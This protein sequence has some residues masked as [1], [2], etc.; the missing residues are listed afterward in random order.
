[1]YSVAII[2]W[3]AA[4]MMCMAKLLADADLRGRTDFL[5]ITLFDT[6]QV[7]GT[8]VRISGW[9]RCNVTTSITDKRQL[10]W[11]YIRGAEFLKKSLGMCGPARIY[12]RFED[13]GVPLKIEDDGRVFPVSN[14]WDDV[15]AVFERLAQHHCIDVK[16]QR[17]VTRVAPLEASSGF[18]LDYAIRWWSTDTMQVDA[19]VLATGGS[20]YRHTGSAGDGY[21][22]AQSCG[23]TITPLGPSLNSFLVGEVGSWLQSISGIAFPHGWFTLSDGRIVRWPL[24]ATHFGCSGPGTF[25]LSAHLAFEPITKEYPYRVFLSP[26]LQYDFGFWQDFFVQQAC[27]NPRKHLKTVL[28]WLMPERALLVWLAQLEIA[29]HTIMAELRKYERNILIAACVRWLPIDFIGRR[30]GDEFVTA[31]WVST[32]EVDSA[33][34]ASRIMP[35]LY[36]V[37]EVLDVDGVTGWF[38]LTSSWAT[39]RVA[40]KTLA[41]NV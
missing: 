32:D 35:W 2:G 31:G 5:R 10:L 12:R 27:E 20:A 29:P 15:V 24:L 40:G 34:C 30:P 33:T 18:C 16:L 6:N 19:V 39:G 4:G 36:L 41:L 22:F 13:Q 8:K 14:D 3:W 17:R 26:N 11:S 9:G 1:M 21:A 38:N 28:Q 37:G 25:Y 7:L 23:H